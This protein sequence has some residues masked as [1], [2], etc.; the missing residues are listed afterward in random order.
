MVAKVVSKKCEVGQEKGPLTLTEI[1]SSLYKSESET[2]TG[3]SSLLLYILTP[4]IL[5]PL[6][7]LLIN[8][9]LLIT[10]PLS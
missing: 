4:P 10:I 2:S 9:P 3:I 8:S 7:L 1:I 6:L 5:P